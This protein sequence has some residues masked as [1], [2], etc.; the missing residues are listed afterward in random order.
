MGLKTPE[1]QVR[2][3]HKSYRRLCDVCARSKI[4]GYSINRIHKTREKLLGDYVS[5]DIDDA[6][7]I[8]LFIK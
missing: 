7:F 5:C 3:F 1:S 2:K 6:L 4:T 8:Y